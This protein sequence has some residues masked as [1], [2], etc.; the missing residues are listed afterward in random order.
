METASTA[1][2]MQTNQRPWWLLLIEG[3][4]LAVVGGFLLWANFPERVEA[5]LF[6]VTVL[7]LYWVVRGVMDIVL[8]F[9]DSTAWGWKLF[10]GIVS[11]IAGTYILMYPVVSAAVLPRIMVLVLG[12]WGLVTGAILI[13]MAFRGGGLG[14]GILGGVEAAIGVILIANYSAPGAGLSLLWVAAIFALVGGIVLIVRAF[15]SRAVVT[16][17]KRARSTA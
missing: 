2:A 6:L 5:Y 16:A 9:S 11:L 12:I 13:L 15:Q 14:T 17:P 7:G 1:M 3:I 4:A 8:I 10:M